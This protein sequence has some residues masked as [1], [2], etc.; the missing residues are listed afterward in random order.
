MVYPEPGSATLDDIGIWKQAL[1]PLQVAQ[2]CS[3]GSTSGRSFDTVAPPTVMVTIS[4]SGGNVTIGYASGTL[5]QSTNLAL[6]M[7]QWKAVPGASAPAFTVPATGA[8][9][10]YRV[11][12]P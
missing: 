11:L 5:L 3:A 8:G 9:N 1:T 12:A 7:S 2:I 6:P 4:H 10:Y